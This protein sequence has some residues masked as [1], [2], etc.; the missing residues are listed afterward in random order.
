[1]RDQENSPK[2]ISSS[3]LEDSS[4]ILGILFASKTFCFCH[5][6][7]ICMCIYVALLSVMHYYNS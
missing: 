7:F 1:M 3:T 2:Y 5:T 6:S 4:L